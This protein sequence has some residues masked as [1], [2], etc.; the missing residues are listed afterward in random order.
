MWPPR[1]PQHWALFRR[2]LPGCSPLPTPRWALP[3]VH[4]QP[5]SPPP[6]RLPPT[7]SAQTHP[8]SDPLPKVGECRAW[9]SQD[10]ELWGLEHTVKEISFIG[11]VS[12][13]APSHR[14]CMS[15]SPIVCL[16]GR[17]PPRAS[18][19]PS[20]QGCSLLCCEWGSWSWASSPCDPGSWRVL[21]LPLHQPTMTQG[22]VTLLDRQVTKAPAGYPKVHKPVSGRDKS[23]VLPCSL[24][25][26]KK[27]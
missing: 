27:L 25:P 16:E 24:Q 20:Q 13:K 8:E 18:Q 22:D 9:D 14:T 11:L 6:V 1:P 7:H 5:H 19:P 17:V 21:A 12:P 15:S 3:V 26:L 4:S 10:R 2:Q 23:G